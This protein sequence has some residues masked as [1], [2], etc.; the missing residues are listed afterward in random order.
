MLTKC[1]K[2]NWKKAAIVMGM[3]ACLALPFNAA[4]KEK[5]TETEAPAEE[6]AA[7]GQVILSTDYPGVSAKPGATVTFPLYIVNQTAA[8]DDAELEAQDLPE[9]W[10]GYFRGSDNEI[11][12]VHV[13]AMQ[14]KADSP[15]LSYSLTIPDEAEDGDYTFTLSA[16]GEQVKA[17]TSLKVM[18]TSQEAG[19]SDFTA[20]YPEQ[21]GDSTTK[22]SF[23][24]TIINNRLTPQSYSL[25]A[26]APEG[27]SVSFTP[28][29]ASSKVAS[30]PVDAGKSQG[31]T[32]AVAPSETVSQ[33]EYTIPLSATS[34]DDTLTLELKIMITGSYGVTLS[35]STGNLSASAYAGE[36]AKV[37]MAVTN[38]GNIDLENLQLAGQ[39]STDWNIRFDETTI[40]VLEAGA[41]KEIT[42]YVQPA[43]NAV[44]GDYVTVMTVSNAQVK[45][46]ADL[47]I[48]VR[49]HTT[50]GVAA[51]AIIAVVCIILALIIRRY[52]R[53]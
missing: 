23:D 19:Q 43:E 52:G 46:E 39:G 45:G 28:S 35:T 50:W 41:T 32:V 1:A 17:E 26:Q 49:N 6:T 9:G 34:A 27:W 14:E 2:S 48:S 29:G 8:D 33:G 12:S 18:I 20:Q 22:F 53:R 4:A 37:T 5:E 15:K 30:V 38:T 51:I 47:R 40:P 42:A 3:A 10:S 11:S 7:S 36:E 21:Q 16:E 13:S 31:L 25:A 24:T 44:I